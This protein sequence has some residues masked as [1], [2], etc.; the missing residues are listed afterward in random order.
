[1]RKLIAAVLAVCIVCTLCAFIMTGCEDPADTTQPTAVTVDKSGDYITLKLPVGR[2]SV[3]VMQITDVHLVGGS[4]TGL[5]GGATRDSWTLACIRDLVELKKP[6]LVIFTG[7]ISYVESMLNGIN[8]GKTK[9]NLGRFTDL[10]DLME[11]LDVFWGVTFGNHDVT[12]TYTKKAIAETLAEEYECFL[13]K[14]SP[15]DVDGDSNYVINVINGDGSFNSSLVMVD[16]HGNSAGGGYTLPSQV[17]WY[18]N[19]LNA[20]K[21]EYSLSQLPTSYVYCHVP[22]IQYSTANSLYL[23]ELQKIGGNQ[24]DAVT[25]SAA[26][27]TL[28][29]AAGSKMR[30]DLCYADDDDG[31]MFEK[32][33]ELGSTKAV[34]CG[35]DHINVGRWTYQGVDLIYG[36]SIDYCAYSSTVGGKLADK[37]I[38]DIGMTN[39]CRG[40]TVINISKTGHSVDFVAYDRDL[41]TE[42]VTANA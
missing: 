27:V 11:E 42:W 6:D 2:D 8:N 24:G 16:T 10:A 26:D 13:Y 36:K 17:T 28:N 23:S 32:I 22:Y 31:K 12:G 5:R 35:H 9:D 4:A 1:M 18:E 37:E 38:E 33:L 29:V 40:A 20:V 21:T 3:N 25:Y 30:E 34:S 19:V 41:Y 7:D 39:E 15:E 14:Q